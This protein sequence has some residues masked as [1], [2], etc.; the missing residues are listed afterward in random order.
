MKSCSALCVIL[1]GQADRAEKEHFSDHLLEFI[2]HTDFT[3]KS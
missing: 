3:D 2:C 1:L